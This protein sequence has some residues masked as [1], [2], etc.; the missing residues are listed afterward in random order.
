MS[1]SPANKVAAYT[2]IALSLIIIIYT[3]RKRDTRNNRVLMDTSESNLRIHRLV[4]YI[5]KKKH[6]L[7]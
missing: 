3:W 2:G 6:L 4:Y 5:P 1:Y 7:D